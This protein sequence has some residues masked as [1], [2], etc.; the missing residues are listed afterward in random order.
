MGI[1]EVEVIGLEKRSD[2]FRIA[3]KKF[4]QHLTVVNVVAT[5]RCHRRR[6]VMEQLILLDRFDY[7]LLIECLV[8]CC[9][10]VGGHILYPLVHVLCILL[11]EVLLCTTLP[12]VS[13]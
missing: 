12:I 7:H 11:V 3:F 1:S 2:K 8:W 9:I 5:L 6:C 13:S 4:V 10:E